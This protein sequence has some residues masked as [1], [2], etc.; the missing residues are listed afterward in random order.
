MALKNITRRELLQASAAL[1]CLAATPFSLAASEPGN[2]E[3]ARSSAVANPLKPP[4]RGSIPVAFLV[5]EG[6]VVIDFC[7]PWEVFQDVMVPGHMDM[8]FQLFTVSEK[9]NPIEVSGGMKIT[10]NFTYENAPAAKVVVIPAQS[11]PSEATLEWVRKSAKSADV[12]MS[13]CTGAYLLAQTGLLAGKAATTH[14]G[15]YIDFARKYP[16]VRVKRGARFVEDGNLASA[17]GLSSGIDLALRV[18]ERYYGR[19]LAKQTAYDMEYQGQGWTSPDSN[20]VYAKLRTSM[21]NRPLCVV[22]S[23][24]VDPVTALKSIYQGKTY[25]FCSTD[26]K[27]I[28]DAAPAEFTKAM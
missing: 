26:H 12:V 18:V 9:A 6:A 25:Y 2:T 8:A 21:D 27:S 19:E 13:V 24:A 23:M 15:S 28:F 3:P 22:C 16:D 4:A 14:H 11:A 7:G 5:S 20:E 17:G 10:P 1:G